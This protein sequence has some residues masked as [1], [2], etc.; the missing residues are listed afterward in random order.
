M[1]RPGTSLLSVALSGILS[2][3][4]FLAYKMQSVDQL[5][6]MFP[7]SSDTSVRLARTHISEAGSLVVLALA[8][9]CLVFSFASHFIASIGVISPL[10]YC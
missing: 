5:I 8:A 10:L 3:P 7:R 1:T 6:P 9:F 4:R 2:Q